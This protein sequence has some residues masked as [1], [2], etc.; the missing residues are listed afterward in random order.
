MKCLKSKIFLF[1]TFICVLLP[2]FEI[3][4]SASDLQYIPSRVIVT[5]CIVDEGGLEPNSV[6]TVS[7]M[8]KNTSTSQ[9]VYSVLVTA[10]WKNTT[11]SPT[12][13]VNINQYY[14]E[15]IKPHEIVSADFEIR[16]K[17]VEL[18]SANSIQCSLVISYYTVNTY[19]END[20][21]E[22]PTLKKYSELYANEVLVQIPVLQ[23]AE[24]NHVIESF[25]DTSNNIAGSN[26]SIFSLNLSSRQK[27]YISGFF[28][29]LV[30][31]I[32]LLIHEK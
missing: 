14:I 13:F 2:L 23:D 31:V 28:V 30:I 21:T 5:D 4:I 10:Q 20:G 19:T 9:S 18:S 1:I 11:T 12:E 29:C 25:E 16:T 26:S 24:H 17:A 32:V 22:T 8:L 3:Q 6:K 15:E 27:I 7:F